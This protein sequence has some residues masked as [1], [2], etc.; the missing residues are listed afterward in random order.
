MSSD[1]EMEKQ[2]QAFVAA[3][4]GGGGQA[5]KRM[6]FNSIVCTFA[7]QSCLVTFVQCACVCS[8][9]ALTSAQ[10]VGYAR[11]SNKGPVGPR[12]DYIQCVVAVHQHWQ[13]GQGSVL[14][15]CVLE[16][17]YTCGLC[18]VVGEGLPEGVSCHMVPFQAF[19]HG[20]E[21]LPPKKLF[22][23]KKQKVCF[24]FLKTFFFF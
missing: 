17:V 13:L 7:I 18:G 21:N 9:C 22:P 11:A 24:H 23:Q 16:R 1:E 3:M 10:R 5:R 20:W 12:V 2:G 4:H 15:M 14:C 6:P 8:K 19:R